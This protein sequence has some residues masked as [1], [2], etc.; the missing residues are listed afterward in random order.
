M[1]EYIKIVL[2][3]AIFVV[4]IAIFGP[5]I[6][7]LLR[8]KNKTK[9]DWIKFFL[10]LFIFILSSIMVVLAENMLIS[11]W[12]KQ[13]IKTTSSEFSSISEPQSIQNYNETSTSI[14]ESSNVSENISL[15]DMNYVEQDINKYADL[16]V[17]YN[18]KIN[19][20]T[21]EQAL[22][23]SCKYFCKGSSPQIREFVI[24][25]KYS[26]LKAQLLVMDS[27]SDTHVVRIKTD[28]NEWIEYF[29]EP[30]NPVDVNVDI[31]DVARLTIE[32]NAP[33]KLK[34]PIEEGVDLAAGN[35]GGGFPGIALVNPI[36]IP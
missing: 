32:F 16:D 6:Y 24:G 4:L 28:N 29:V 13:D 10:G 22:T 33:N 36:L 17:V 7:D 31:K 20:N 23:Y 12:G 14:S 11:N 35:G 8:K 5:L 9:K 26:L 3:Y 15:L 21:F 18:L 25:R 2:Y 1:F 34:S 30:G 27:S 19:G